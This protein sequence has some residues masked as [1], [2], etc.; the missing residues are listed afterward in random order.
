V[1]NAICNESIIDTNK[2]TGFE[3]D[4]FMIITQTSKKPIDKTTQKIIAIIDKLTSKSTF[5]TIDA[6]SKAT[7][8]NSKT[9][10]LIIHSSSKVIKSPT[11]VKGVNWIIEVT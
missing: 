6:T 10:S 9:I 7:N 5:A 8:T 2:V 4:T 11:N 3:F 1:P